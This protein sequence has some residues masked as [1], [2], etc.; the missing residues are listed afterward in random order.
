MLLLDSHC[1][2]RHY[3]AGRANCNALSLEEGILLEFI[4][5]VLMSWLDPT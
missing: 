4:L 1:P 5:M 2:G 3:H